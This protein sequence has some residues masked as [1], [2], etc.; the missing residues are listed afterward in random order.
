MPSPIR[1]LAVGSC[2]PPHHLGG[3][4]IIWAGVTEALRQAGHETR[5]LTSDYRRPGVGSENASDDVHRELDW[6]WRDHA[7]RSLGPRQCLALERHNAAV[8][9]RHVRAFRPDV[10]TWWPMGGMSLGLIERA[11]GLALPSA[12]FVLDPWLAYGPRHDLWIRNWARLGPLAGL[13]ERLTRLPARVDFSH[14]GRWVF[15]SEEMRRQA[16]CTGLQTSDSTVL[17]PGVARQ[18]LRATRDHDPPQWGW[19]LLYIGRVVQQKGIH[20]AIAALPELPSQSELLI[21]GEGDPAYRQS[22]HDLAARLGVTARVRF[23]PPHPRHEL[24]DLYRAAD[25]VLFP[26]QWSEPW[27]LVPLEAM[28]VGRPVIAT[29]RGGSGEYLVDGANA[30]LF[31]AGDPRALAGAVRELASSPELRAQVVRGGYETAARLSED[32]FNRRAVAE[33]EALAPARA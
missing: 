6:Y 5:V 20:T 17:K 13:A 8:F 27:G 33:V 31:G 30:R 26:V 18:F 25:A 2:Y 15:C 16:F 32:E 11:R 1:V 3:Y 9:E 12:L 21:V 7:W 22:L 14:A 23:E 4:E 29:G 24:I 10:V 19:R 28:A